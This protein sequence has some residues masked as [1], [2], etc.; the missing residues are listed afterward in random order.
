MENNDIETLE[1]QKQDNA[2]LLFEMKQRIKE[3]REKEKQE[4]KEIREKARTLK[5]QIEEIDSSI[6]ICAVCG[7][8]DLSI[9]CQEHFCLNICV[10]PNCYDKMLINKRDMLIAKR[11][12]YKKEVEKRISQIDNEIAQYDRLSKIGWE[13][14]VKDIINIT[15]I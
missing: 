13:N 4:R 14:T 15:T 3:M 8:K 12:E 2:K 10:C 7:E 9:N 5:K 6:D 11:E 1:K